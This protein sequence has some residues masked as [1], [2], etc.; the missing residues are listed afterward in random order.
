[1]HIF[2]LLYVN[3][4]LAFFHL[5]HQTAKWTHRHT[6]ICYAIVN[7]RA[8]RNECKNSISTEDLLFI[9][10]CFHFSLLQFG[11][12]FA[13]GSLSVFC[14]VVLWCRRLWNAILFELRCVLYAI[15]KDPIFIQT[16]IEYWLCC[17][18]SLQ[19]LV[20]YI[21]VCTIQHMRNNIYLNFKLV[22]I[23]HNNNTECCCWPEI[24]RLIHTCALLQM[25]QS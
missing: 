25:A 15:S 3:T 2:H 11:S 20:P 19:Q 4:K 18:L 12:I 24:S 5:R 22:V 16:L 14:F 6:K 17:W 8:N 1:M 7:T 9:I 13:F 21:F 23:S 10:A